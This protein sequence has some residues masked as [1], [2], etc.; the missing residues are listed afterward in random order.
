MGKQSK[1]GKSRVA[2]AGWPGAGRPWEVARDPLARGQLV[3]VPLCGKRIMRP[4]EESK[5]E[6]PCFVRAY[7]GGVGV[8]KLH[9]DWQVKVLPASPEKTWLPKRRYGWGSVNSNPCLALESICS[10]CIGEGRQ[11]VNQ[12]CLWA[13]SLGTVSPFPFSFP[14]LGMNTQSQGFPFTS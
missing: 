12:S 9:F 6:E 8:R 2:K 10:F 4:R 13:L 3:R 1:G 14:G 7:I 5:R 11:A